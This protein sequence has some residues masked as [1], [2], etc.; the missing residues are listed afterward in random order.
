MCKKI[1]KYIIKKRYICWSII[2]ALSVFFLFAY[3]I[4]E[5]MLR[6]DQYATTIF[7]TTAGVVGS[8]FGLTAASYAFI[9]GELRSDRQAN[10]HLE[11]VLG[12]YRKRLWN[13]CIACRDSFGRN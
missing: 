3:F 4:Q 13:L 2:T 8:M 6:L 12:N 10:R 1:Q 7:A 11:R 5:K 9:W